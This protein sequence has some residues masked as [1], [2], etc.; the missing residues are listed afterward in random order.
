MIAAAVLDF[1]TTIRALI[2]DEAARWGVGTDELFR[3]GLDHVREQDVPD[4]MD[5][6]GA[7]YQVLA[8]S[9]LFTATWLLMLDRFLEPSEHGALVAVPSRHV[10]VFAP[11]V[12]LGVMDVIQEM[13]P[14]V[15]DCYEAGPGSIS[16]AL[17]WRRGEELTLLPS[18]LRH[19][20]FYFKPPADFV[21]MLASLP[22]PKSQAG[23]GQTPAAIRPNR[24]ERRRRKASGRS[25]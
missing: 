21:D 24:E 8:G 12:E 22:E 10:I 7:P 14:F 5:L 6:P 3:L 23:E 18:Q 13:V 16:S 1:P 2:Q 11:I 17:Y 15:R 9:S 20:S 25:W 19:G 4:R